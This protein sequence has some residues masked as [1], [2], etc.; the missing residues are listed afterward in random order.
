VSQ[1]FNSVE[2]LRAHVDFLV[3]AN[4]DTLKSILVNGMTRAYEL[5]GGM[6]VFN[7]A[8]SSNDQQGL[9]RPPSSE[10]IQYATETAASAVTGINETTRKLINDA[11]VR[12]LQDQLGVPGTASEVRKTLDGMSSYRARSIAT[13][14]INSAMS[15]A[16]LN[17]IKRVGLPLKRWVARANCC[18]IC[19]ANKAAGAIPVDQPFPSGH[20]RPPAHPGKCRCAIV[21]VQGDENGND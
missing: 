4:S 15:E 5:A 6:S 3:T 9:D 7:E 11:I 19:S 18:P 17:K 2:H 21:G 14:E 20:Q 1:E 10:V 13:T 8:A 12:G 16:T